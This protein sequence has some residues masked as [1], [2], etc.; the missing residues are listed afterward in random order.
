MYK[1]LRETEGAKNENENL[2]KNVLNKLK[3]A[4]KNVPENNTFMIEENEK[5]I[6]I[7]KNI[8]NFNQ[9]GEGLKILSLN[10]MFSRLPIS[11][12]N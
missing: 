5:I 6:N 8:L 4:I 9:S 10:Q 7:V 11:L 2:I 1:N 3:K 12:V